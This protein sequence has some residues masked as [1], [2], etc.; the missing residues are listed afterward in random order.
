VAF[1]YPSEIWDYDK[2]QEKEKSKSIRQMVWASIWIDERGKPR[3]SELAMERDP[4]APREGYSSKSYI[5]TLSKR[6]IASL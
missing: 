4:E 3:R 2:I 1:C 6:F 5:A